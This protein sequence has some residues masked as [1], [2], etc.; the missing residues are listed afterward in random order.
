MQTFQVEELVARNRKAGKPWLEFLR[1]PALSAGIY[2]LPAGSEDK[3]QPHSED[4]IYYVLEG[5][6]SFQAGDN[7]GKV[8]PGAILHVEAKVD[9][10]FFDIK[11]DLTTLVVF[12]P[13]E[14]SQSR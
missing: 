13:A 1:V 14:G 5:R 12:A 10:R 2:R 8:R 9:H 7:V 4:E 3:Q 11:E 6:A